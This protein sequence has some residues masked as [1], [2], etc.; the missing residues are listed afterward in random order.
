MGYGLGACSVVVKSGLSNL[1]ILVTGLQSRG[2]TN[3]DSC[4]KID[5]LDVTRC[6]ISPF[7]A[8]HVSNVSTSM[9]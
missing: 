2:I 3:N 8:Q 7:T 5:Q 9:Y 1:E 4:I 6:I